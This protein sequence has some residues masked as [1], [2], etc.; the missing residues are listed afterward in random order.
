MTSWS[1]RCRQ[2][3]AAWVIVACLPLGLAGHVPVPESV[4]NPQS[5]PEAWNVLRLAS[6]NLDRLVGE[7]RL[8]EVPDQASLCPAS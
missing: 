4:L 7:G 5:V 2:W 6:A 8:E 3:L 1:D